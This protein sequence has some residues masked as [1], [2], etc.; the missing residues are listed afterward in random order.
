MWPKTLLIDNEK[1]SYSSQT[2]TTFAVAARAQDG[3]TAAAHAHSSTATIVSNWRDKI[4]DSADYNRTSARYY[5]DGDATIDPLSPPPATGYHT[6][7][8]RTYLGPNNWNLGPP[9]GHILL[10]DLA[11]LNYQL[12]D[13]CN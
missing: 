4:V 12:N 3:T 5:T 9:D 13:H 6:A 8:D 7:F 11:A 1:F 2:S 10:S